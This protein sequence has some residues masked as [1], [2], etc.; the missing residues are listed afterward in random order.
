MY[1]ESIA[2]LGE[3]AFRTSSLKCS[4]YIAVLI[5][6]IYLDDLLYVRDRRDPR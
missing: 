3:T 2:N 6:N 4:V 1:L 5:A